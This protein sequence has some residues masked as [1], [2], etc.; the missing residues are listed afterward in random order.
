[1]KKLLSVLALSTALSVPAL[2]NAGPAAAP[3]PACPEMPAP[4][5]GG[6]KV[7]MQLGYAHGV[8]SLKFD[9]IELP[10]QSSTSS[11]SSSSSNNNPAFGTI[12]DSDL[13]DGGTL[14]L[15]AKGVFGGVHGAYDF[16]FN[17]NWIIGAEA[18]FDFVQNSLAKYTV[19]VVP[20][21]GYGLNDS[22]FYV[23]AGWAGTKFD[24]E[25][26]NAF[27]LALGAAQ[28]MGRVLLGVEADYDFY[29]HSTRVLEG[30]VKL[31]F[32]L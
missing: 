21:V 5:W 7:G 24:H 18:S 19:A 10:A 20:R 30:K 3:C 26:E 32:M 25:F 17:R 11:S 6:F 4:K 22:L 27:R 12:S 28:K 23:G 13:A 8:T 31:S 16:Q 14:H 29:R 2:S 1:M 9:G 15:G